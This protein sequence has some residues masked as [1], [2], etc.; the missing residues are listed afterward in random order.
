MTFKTLTQ[1]KIF[2]PLLVATFSVAAGLILWSQNHGGYRDNGAYDGG[3]LASASFDYL[4]KFAIRTNKEPVVLIV[5]D[6][7]SYND[8]ELSQARGQPWARELHAKL[9]NQLADDGCPLVVMDIFFRYAENSPADIALAAALRRLTNVVLLAKQNP[10]ALPGSE[11]HKT[12]LPA[13]IFLNAARTNWGIGWLSPDFDNTVRRHWPF[14]SSGEYTSL[15]WKAAVVSH[16]HLPRQPVE[17]WLRYY[18]S[19]DRSYAISYRLALHKAPGFFKN[20][21][22]FIGNQPLNSLASYTEEDKFKTPFDEAVGGAEIQVAEYLNLVNNE[23]LVRSDWIFEALLFIVTGCVFGIIL[24]FFRKFAAVGVAVGCMILFGIAAISLS[25]VTNYWF[26]WLIVVG[27]QIP[28]ACVLA[29]ALPLEERTQVFAPVKERPPRDKTIVVK[30]I[31][32]ELPDAPDYELVDPPFGEG[33]FGKVWLARNAIGQWQALKVI[34]QSKFGNDPRPFDAEFRGI[35]KYK[36]VSE[37]HPALLRV[38]LVSKKKPDGYFYYV[39]ELGD[40]RD[41]NWETQ[42]SLY[43]P[44][45]LEF[46]RKQ[47]EN[48]R[49]PI[50]ECVRITIVLAEALDFLHRAGLTHRDIKP[51]N[52]IFV[53]GRPKLADVGLV[54]AVRPLDQ[55][56]TIVGTLGYM[57]PPPE[58]TGTVQADIYA[59]GMLLY[60]IST[61]SDPQ[62]FPD[63]AT[64]LIERSGHADFIRVNAIILKACQPDCALRYQTTEEMLSALHETAKALGIS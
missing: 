37:Q 45:D 26:P 9:L 60:V 6:N 56:Q 30:P 34:Y 12:E 38:E 64:T 11:I 33:G 31:D 50:H 7:D 21:I 5:I 28:V 32:P 41:P 48:R 1:H 14:P 57:P 13:D 25:C 55:V 20:K 47:A 27:A 23:A 52:V 29:I 15:A 2:R 8:P 44:K 42:P 24:S 10:A 17:R 36:P 22:V 46:V 58:R 3:P 43:K 51:P 49:L 59:L 19:D 54:A 62:Y 35:Q 18:G 39:M 63:L 61:G 4:S 40:S 53:K 16:A